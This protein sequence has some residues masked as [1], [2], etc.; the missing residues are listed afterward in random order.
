MLRRRRCFALIVLLSLLA[1]AGCGGNGGNL[2]KVWGR[3]GLQPG[4]LIRP[5]AA[6]IDTRDGRDLLYVVDF[7]ARIQVYN[8]DGEYQQRTWATPES[9]NG[10]PS[11]I[12]LALN[13]DILIAD[14]HYQRVLIYSPEG[15]LRGQIG[16]KYGKEPGE[17]GYVSDVVQDKDGNF[18]VAEFG[19]NDRIQK[20]SREWKYLKHWGSPGLEPGQFARP[21]ALAI[22]PDGYLYVADACNH[23]IQVFDLEGQLVRCW[24]QQGHGPGELYYPYDLAFS[25]TNGDLY[26]VEYGNHRVQRFSATG[27]SRGTWGKPG[28][29]PGCL[30]SPWALAIDSRG[31]VHVIDSENHRVQRI[32]F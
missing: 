26:V 2:E 14:S 6:M 15:E 22:G 12:G 27:E 8:R 24:G 1:V 18:Y 4:D 30:Q 17:F 20:F 32:E 29:Q 13:G 23:R 25:P 31:R 9:V 7:T 19:E 5:R 28:R 21:R 16:G 3:R 10:R 11:G